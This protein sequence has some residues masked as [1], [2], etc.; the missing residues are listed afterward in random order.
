MSD[1][2]LETLKEYLEIINKD[3]AFHFE[4][5]V[6]NLEKHLSTYTQ[7]TIDDVQKRF[8]L[9]IDSLKSEILEIARVLKENVEDKALVAEA[10]SIE[11]LINLK[12]NAASAL[13]ASEKAIAKSE[14][15]YDKRFDAANEIKAA[16]A[17]QGSEMATRVEVAQQMQSILDKIE[18]AT[19]LSHRVS[20][21][22]S[23]VDTT[24][25]SLGASA[26]ASANSTQQRNWVLGIVAAAIIAFSVAFF[27]SKTT[28]PQPTYLTPP[29]SYSQ[30]VIPQTNIPQT[31]TVLP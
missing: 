16:M 10:R 11:R 21:I 4:A 31:Q 20:D 6:D 24:I 13:A 30:P 1:W 7:K 14:L 29:P 22:G 9:S 26:N 12:E 3:S 28:G 19:G 5:R 17:K 25:A 23:R 2:T 18:G 8:Q 27:T 15:A